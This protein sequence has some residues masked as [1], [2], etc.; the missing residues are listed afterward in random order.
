MG[1]FTR[2]ITDNS[3]VE[4][5]KGEF[6]SFNTYMINADAYNL[7]GEHT[8][9]FWNFYNEEKESR[10]P[11]WYILRSGS[12]DKENLIKTV[13]RMWEAANDEKTDLNQIDQIMDYLDPVEKIEN[14]EENIRVRRLIKIL[15]ERVKKNTEN[16]QRTTPNPN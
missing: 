5:A 8:S 16:E 7:S 9:C 3:L 11:L 15:K 13:C 2:Y 12:G 6:P 10:E 14:T 4:F 1:F